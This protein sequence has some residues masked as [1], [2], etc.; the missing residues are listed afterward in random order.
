MP[1]MKHHDGEIKIVRVT[2]SSVM[3]TINFPNGW[4]QAQR[5]AN[6]PEARSYANGFADGMKAVSNLIGHGPHVDSRIEIHKESK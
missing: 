5:C 6:E 1:Q 4:Q 2:E 3:V